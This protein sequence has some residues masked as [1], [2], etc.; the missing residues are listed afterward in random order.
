MELDT[1]QGE[2]LRAEM[3]TISTAQSCSWVKLEQSPVSSQALAQG[4][5]AVARA[6]SLV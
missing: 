6:S 5:L 1:Y 4:F 2:W 3:F